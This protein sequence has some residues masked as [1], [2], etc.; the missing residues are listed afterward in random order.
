MIY[1]EEDIARHRKMVMAGALVDKQ[2][3]REHGRNAPVGYGLPA[4]LGLYTAGIGY[5]RE[6]L[7]DGFLPDEFLATFPGKCGALCI[8]TALTDRRVKLWHRVRGGYRIHDFRKHNESADKIKHR[9]ELGRKRKQQQRFRQRNTEQLSLLDDG[10]SMTVLPA[11]MSPESRHFSPVDSR[12]NVDGIDR[13]FEA[14]FIEVVSMS[15]VTSSVTGGVTEA[16]SR[17][18]LVPL[19]PLTDVRTTT[20]VPSTSVLPS[21]NDRGIKNPPDERA[22]IPDTFLT[23]RVLAWRRQRSFGTDGVGQPKADTLRA[24]VRSLI[25]EHGEDADCFDIIDIAKT[26]CAKA[27]LRYD[28]RSLYEAYSGARRQLAHIERR[29]EQKREREGYAS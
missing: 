15:R 10:A 6:H 12:G 17:V 13:E 18:P 21:T 1:L 14:E 20:N 7:T 8:A 24:V 25:E 4:A 9:R 22:E 27:N 29:R 5:A 28:S 16:V 23:S 11:E 26:V 2:I 19:V 3:E